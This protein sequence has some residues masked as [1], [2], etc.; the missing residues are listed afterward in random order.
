LELQGFE[1]IE[2]TPGFALLRITARSAASAASDSVP[3]LL[4]DDTNTVHRFSALPEAS[5]SGGLLCCAFPVPLAILQQPVSFALELSDGS[6]IE[7]PEPTRAASATRHVA[8]LEERLRELIETTAM[9]KVT[10]EGARA[11]AAERAEMAAR[12]EQRLRDSIAAAAQRE[13]A[14]EVVRA[15]ASEHNA[16]A[17]GLQSE[18]E[19]AKADALAIAH[20]YEQEAAARAETEALAERLELELAGAREDAEAWRE[21]AEK[22][23]MSAAAAVAEARAARRGAAARPDRSS[24]TD[25]TIGEAPGPEIAERLTAAQEMAERQAANREALR[26]R[27]RELKQRSAERRK[28]RGTAPPTPGSKPDSDQTPDAA[29]DKPRWPPGKPRGSGRD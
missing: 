5:G 29:S 6:I 4:V 27:E 25:S 19:Q 9:L 10:A 23:R 17:L 8:A 13:A 15:E 7:L 20:S 24:E 28:G 11:Q 21:D 1:Q 2:A 12:L 18:L 26:A 14:H 22:A 16:R 3:V